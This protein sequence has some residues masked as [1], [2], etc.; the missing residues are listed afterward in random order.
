ME[1]RD[2]SARRCARGGAGRSREQDGGAPAHASGWRRLGLARETGGVVAR[3]VHPVI[4]SGGHRPESKDLDAHRQTATSEVHAR[5][6]DRRQLVA[7][8]SPGETVASRSFDKLRMTRGGEHRTDGSGHASSSPT[9]SVASLRMTGDGDVRRRGCGPRAPVGGLSL[10][11]SP[12]PRPG[13]P[14]RLRAGVCPRGSTLDAQIASHRS[15]WRRSAMICPRWWLLW[16]AT[17][18]SSRR[19]V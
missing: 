10:A 9:R 16:S 6:P 4:L 7:A 1:G 3:S 8:A 17:R 13:R 11:R 18:R 19:S 12:L 15:S 2:S 5:G 14:A